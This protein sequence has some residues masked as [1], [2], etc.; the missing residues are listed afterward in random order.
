MI[1][2]VVIDVLGTDYHIEHK[3]YNKN[4]FGDCDGYC[5]LY[6]KVIAICDMMTEPNMMNEPKEV[7]DEVEKRVL[8][9]EII[10]AFLF[11]SGLATDSKGATAWAE[12]EEMIDWFAIQGPK[13]LKIWQE[14]GV[15]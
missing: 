2:P 9:H 15:A 4:D 1:L 13:I 8:R 7:R 12:N 5:K 14:A 11:E 6:E 3:P 10:H